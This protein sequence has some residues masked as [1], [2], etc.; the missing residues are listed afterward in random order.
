LFEE[1]EKRAKEKDIKRIYVSTSCDNIPAII[2]HLKR[3][4]LYSKDELDK[5][6]EEIGYEPLIA[7]SG[8]SAQPLKQDSPRMLLVYRKG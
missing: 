3:L 6:A 4:R 1:L 5:L 2:Y 7:L 8:L